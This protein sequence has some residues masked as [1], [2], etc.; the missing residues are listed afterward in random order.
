MDF[1]YKLKFISHTDQGTVNLGDRVIDLKT[2]I[3]FEHDFVI[4]MGQGK[5]ILSIKNLPA[6]IS[7][8]LEIYE[9]KVNDFKIKN[10]Q[11]YTSF[12]MK[13]NPYVQNR[14]IK[15]KFLVFN[16]ELFLDVDYDRLLWFPH[17]Y[18]KDRIDFTYSNNLVSC[19]GEEGCWDGEKTEHEDQYVNVPFHPSISPMMGDKFGLGCSMTYGTGVDKKLTWPALIG[20]HNL[21]IPGS[22]IDAIYYNA[23][24]LTD[25][26]RPKKMIIL[27]PGMARGLIEFERN[28]YFFRV[29]VGV[30]QPLGSLY[31]EDYFWISSREISE[32][33]QKTQKEMVLDENHEYSHTYLRDRKSVV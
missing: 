23:R 21:A 3:E 11:T 13:D 5:Q 7:K 33:A 8:G 10:P 25:L 9:M 24:R 28:G 1:K 4:A 15:E 14:M 30:A 27:F 29:P 12:R 22:G 31:D 18:S 2:G 20:Y 32:M 26:Y 19:Q 17:F 16:G 6:G